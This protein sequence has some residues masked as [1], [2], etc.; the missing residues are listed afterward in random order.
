MRVGDPEHQRQLDVI[1]TIPSNKVDEVD[2]SG[3]T[4]QEMA[5]F[6]NQ[7]EKDLRA[8]V[9]AYDETDL[10]I[11]AEEI[12]KIGWTYTYNALGDYFEKIIKQQ[13]TINATI[14]NE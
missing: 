14:N 4:K 6:E 1:T 8:Q 9:R 7:H 12:T 13:A 3:L 11:V 10:R 5:E 2:L